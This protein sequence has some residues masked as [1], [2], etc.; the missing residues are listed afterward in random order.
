MTVLFRTLF[1]VQFTQNQIRKFEKRNLDHIAQTYNFPSTKYGKGLYW[2]LAGDTNDLKLVSILNLSPNM[3]S[4]VLSPTRLNPDRILD[5][6]ITDMSKWYQT[7]KCLP[8]LNGDVGS[9]GKPSDHLTVI[10]EPICVLNNKPART[11]REVTVRP[12]KQ[13]GIDLFEDWLKK[14]TWQ[15]VFKA[16]TVDKK[17]ETLQ[18]MLMNKVDDP[19]LCPR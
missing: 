13:S 19:E 2:I 14:Q 11:T 15:E 12:L 9:G 8:P 18:N 17:A 16:E 1:W 4:V 6:I 3:K 10:M 5:N 7:P